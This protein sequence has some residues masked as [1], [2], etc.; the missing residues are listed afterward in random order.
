MKFKKAFLAVILVFVLMT[1]SACSM[2]DDS[3]SVRLN[4][5]GGTV[6]SNLKSYTPGEEVTLP[7]PEREHYSFE[8]WYDNANFNGDAYEKIPET[9]TGKQ[10]FWAKWMPDVF[11]VTLN[12]NGGTVVSPLTEYTY[13]VGATLPS[14]TK[15]GSE[16]LGWVDSQN[17]TVTSISETDFGNKEFWAQWSG[18]GVSYNL[19]LNLVGGKLDNAPVS[20]T[21]GVET[22][23]PQPTKTG[24]DF[25]GW[26]NDA[27]YSGTAVTKIS[28]SDEGDKQFWAKWEPQAQINVTAFGGYNEGAYIEFDTVSSA[29]TYTVKYSVAG[30]NSFTAID[31]ELVRV[32]SKAGKVRADIVGIKAGSYDITVTTNNNK[33]V[34]K[35]NVAVTSYDRSG[36]AHFDG[37]RSDKTVANDNGVGGYKN[38]GTPKS[39]AYIIYVSEETKNTVPAPWNNKVKGLARVLAD[40]QNSNKPVII[41]VIGRIAAATWKPIKYTKPTSGYLDADKLISQTQTITGKT[42]TKKDYTQEEL[43]N[44]KVN[45]LNETNGITELEGMEKTS[46]MTFDEATD[47]KPDRFDSCWN[48]CVI[49]NANN[50][51][52]E[53]IGADAEFFQ[54]GMTWKAEKSSNGVAKASNIEVRNLTFKDNTEDACSFEGSTDQTGSDGI[55]KFDFR[56]IWLHNNTFYIG[57]NYWDVCE[58]QDK[59]DGDGSTDFKKLSYVT[60]SYNTYVKT[61][62]TGLIG[63]SDSQKTASITFHHN[64]YDRCGSRLP[65]GR[66]ANMHMYNNYYYG[67]TGTNMSLR[68]N[69]YALI[70]NCY[71]EKCNNPIE[72]GDSSAVAKVLGCTFTGC[73]KSTKN[74]CI[75]ANNASSRTATVTNNNLFSTSFDTSSTLFYYANNKSN[76]KDLL[77]ADKVRLACVNNAGALKPSSWVDIMTNSELTAF[78]AARAKEK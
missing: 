66:Q 37:S 58:E 59:Y 60:L 33:S 22:V 73:T 28:A 14:A 40:L 35:S 16:F 63:G 64:F 9:A 48:D 74:E 68:G 72:Y 38:D 77:N 62:K 27:N 30:A 42:L 41:R 24:Y 13:G 15:N 34:T 26:Y 10:T 6:E 3:N 29:S 47:T 69:A 4:L 31:S 12:A 57:K 25:A 65:L 44:L 54:W 2:S 51:T 39:N 23:L 55:D 52:V 17:Q 75:S 53:G 56:R 50:V 36:Y 70:E 8:G 18:S 11:T 7:V 20:Y 1:A 32:D 21:Y 19:T 45:E 78:H 76:V 49:K 46:R 5:N 71:F 61:H 67:S 43:I